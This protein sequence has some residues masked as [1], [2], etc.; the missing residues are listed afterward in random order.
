ML[1]EIL[2]VL[3]DGIDKSLESLRRELSRLR[4]GRANLAILEAVRVDYYGVGTPLNQMASMST[5]DPRT[6]LIKP[7]DRS[8]V[9]AVAKAIN[10]SNLGLTPNVDGEFIRISVPS[11]TEERRR[12]LVKVI[13]KHGEE[14]K[15]AIRTHRRDANE[16]TKSAVDSGDIPEDDGDRGLKKIQ[17]MTDQGVKRVDDVV[18]AKE[19]D[20]MEV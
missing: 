2:E 1:D 20:V 15:V 8:Q 3:K 6:I 18:A 11:L 4:T 16:L 14:A 9:Q 10:Q 7:W 12:D 5:P 17:D 19:T 13:K